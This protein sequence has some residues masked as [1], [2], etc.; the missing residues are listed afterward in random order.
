MTGYSFG[1]ITALKVGQGNKDTVKSVIA[2]D[3]W[4]FPVQEEVNQGLFH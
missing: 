4:Y 2:L 1:G 3:P